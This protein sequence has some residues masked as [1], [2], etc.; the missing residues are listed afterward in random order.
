MGNTIKVRRSSLGGAVPTT[1]QLTAGEIAI[2]TFDGKMFIRRDNGT[3]SIVEIGG[4]AGAAGISSLNALTGSTQTFATG[5]TGNDFSINSSGT[6]HTFNIPDA[7]TTARG[8][9]TTG[10]QT[11]TGTKTLTAPAAAS[12]PLILKGAASQTAPLLQTQNSAGTQT[13]RI[14]VDGT[15]RI[16]QTGENTYYNVSNAFNESIY[17][18]YNNADGGFIYIGTQI[19]F[20]VTFGFDKTRRCFRIY[21]NGE[22]LFFS[23]SLDNGAGKYTLT[24]A[25]D[26]GKVCYNFSVGGTGHGFNFITANSAGGVGVDLAGAPEAKLH[27][28]STGA[29]RKV[30]IARGHA[31]QTA[32]LFEA[33]N[34]SGTVLS[35]VTASG[36]LVVGS[37]AYSMPD[38]SAVVFA[39]STNGLGLKDSSD[40]SGAYYLVCRNSTDGVVGSITRVGTT[41]AVAYNT[42]SDYRMKENVAP[43][44][45]A[46]EKAIQLNPVTYNWKDCGVASQG[47]IAHELQELLPDAVHGEKD[48]VDTSGNPV[49]QGVDYS[50]LTPLLAAAIKEINAKVIALEA[51]VEMQNAKISALENN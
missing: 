18:V 29:T 15:M 43:M 5:T 16:L 41:N 17:A 37:S 31:T 12:S 46:L 20:G 19:Y 47:F 28:N 49:F 25:R 4:S 7:S 26:V 10:S 27:V 35:Y 38:R 9:L 40:T 51:V 21:P 42:A 13:M 8:F 48:A 3:A 32:N 33:Q 36:S 14:N 22:N 30:I 34:S 50:K 1:A 24:I 44:V 6:A 23:E 39:A 2:N 11:I 45:G